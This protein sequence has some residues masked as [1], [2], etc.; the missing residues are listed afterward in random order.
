[1]ISLLVVRGKKFAAEIA[2]ESGCFEL[3]SLFFSLE[4]YHMVNRINI[5]IY[6]VFCGRF[7][8]C[9]CGLGVD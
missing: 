7:M 8:F 1:M 3:R 6:V 4:D 9:F 5:T 2:D